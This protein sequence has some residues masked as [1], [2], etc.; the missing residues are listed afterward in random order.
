MMAF[1]YSFCLMFT[2]DSLNASIDWTKLSASALKEV[3]S[4]TKID[5]DGA[6]D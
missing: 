2:N 1:Y 5:N 6:S 3:L 4:I